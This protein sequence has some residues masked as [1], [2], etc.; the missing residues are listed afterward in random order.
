MALKT[1]TTCKPSEFLKQTNRIRKAAAKWMTATDFFAIRSRKP[2]YET[3]PKDS[4]AEE[5]IEIVKRNAE[6]EKRQIRE[7]IM[8]MLDGILEKHPDETLELLA[9]CC[10]VEPE[11]VD[12]HTVGEYLTAFSELISDEAVLGFFTSLMRLDQTGILTSAKQ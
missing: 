10:F 7:N 9:L 1:L 2:V 11:E 3:V 6:A 12:N 8:A 4:S 5:R